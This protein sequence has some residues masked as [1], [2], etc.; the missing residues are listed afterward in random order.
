MKDAS[1][2]V[3]RLKAKGGKAKNAGISLSASYI[4]WLEQTAEQSG[5]SKSDV[6]RELIDEK[7]T[8]AMEA[9]TG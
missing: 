4:K 1:D 2:F 3:K 7:R 8:P 5:V 6:V 9:I